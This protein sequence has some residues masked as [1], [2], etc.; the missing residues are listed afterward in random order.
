MT[1]S[2]DIHEDV[3]EWAASFPP[4]VHEYKPFACWCGDVHID[5]QLAPLMGMWIMGGMNPYTH[6]PDWPSRD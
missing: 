5:P 6:H 2:P 1:E 4:H 3:F